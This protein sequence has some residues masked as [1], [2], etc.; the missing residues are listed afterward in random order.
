MPTLQKVCAAGHGG[1]RGTAAFGVCGCVSSGVTTAAEAG[2]ITMTTPPV[3]NEKVLEAWQAYLDHGRNKTQAAA[4]LGLDRST[5]RGRLAMAESRG[6]HLPQGVREAI[7]SVGI[8]DTAIVSGGWLKTKDVSVQFR[9]PKPDGMKIDL[10]ADQIKQALKDLESVTLPKPHHTTSELLTLYPLPDIHAGMKYKQWG[11]TDTVE[12]LDYIFDQLISSTPQSK[13]A[14][15]LILG[16]LLHHNDRTNKTQS[17][18][19]L[20]VDCTPE[21]AA[22]AMVTSIARGIE[23]ALLKHEEVIVSV[24]RGNHDRD[25]YLIVLYSLVERYRNEPRVSINKEDSEFLIFPWEDV[26]IFAHH[27]DKGK[28]E[29]MVMNFAHEYREMWGKAKHSYLFTGHLHHLKMADIGGVQW[30]Q[31]R[32]VAPKDAYASSHS[33]VGKSSAVA[34]SY[35]AK[36]GEVSRVTVS[37]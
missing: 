23:M 24:L 6:L 35:Q 8:D 19:T 7:A 9:M 28:P 31:L 34:I 36:H 3:S 4:A 10:A 29:R 5:F 21:D 20:D 33:F 27:G 2:N 15:F 37:F 1:C 16:D 32:A 18:H 11:L 17:G 30:E 12:R 13:T 25:A 26:L 14:L 22:A